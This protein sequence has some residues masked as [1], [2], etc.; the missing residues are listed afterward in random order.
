MKRTLLFTACVLMTLLYGVVYVHAQSNPYGI[1]PGATPVD[2]KTIKVDFESGSIPEGWLNVSVEGDRKWEIRSFDENQYAQMTAFKSG[3]KCTTALVTP[4]IAFAPNNGVGYHLS[5]WLHTGHANGAKMVAKLLDK[6]G[7]EVKVLDEFIQADHAGFA[8]FWDERKVFIPDTTE[9][10]YISFEYVGNDDPAAGPILTTT[11]QIDDIEIDFADAKKELTASVESY[12]F[13]TRDLGSSQTLEISYLGRNLPGEIAF[14]VEESD[15]FT[16]APSTLPKE[17]GK[18]TVTFKPMKGGNHF[19]L[20]KATSGET[21]TVTKL[22][23]RGADKNN[24]YNVST[25]MTPK[26]LNEDFETETADFSLPKYWTEATV[27]ARLSWTVKKYNGNRLI[28]INPFGLGLEVQT[29]VVTPLIDMDPTKDY[30]L[31]FDYNWAF[32][33]GAELAIKLLDAT[34]KPIQEL[35][36][37]SHNDNEVWKK[38]LSTMELLLPRGTDDCFIAFEYNGND[39]HEK[40]NKRTTAYQLDNIRVYSESSLPAS[41]IEVSPKVIDFETPFMIDEDDDLP[42][43]VVGKGLTEEISLSLKENKGFTIDKNTLPASGGT[44]QVH[45]EATKKGVFSTELILKS[46]AVTQV[47]PLKAEVKGEEGGDTPVEK[48]YTFDTAA[49][50]IDLNE[51]F[52]SKQMPSGW[53]SQALEGTRSWVIKTHDDNSYI[54]MTGYKAEGKL[55]VGLISPLVAMDATK[56]YELHFDYKVGFANGA[57]LSVKLYD[58]TGKL[59]KELKKIVATEPASGYSETFLKETLSLPKGSAN[60]FILFEYQGDG[61]SK[62]TTTYQIDNVKVSVKEKDPNGSK[63]VE[64][65]SLPFIVRGNEVVVTKEGNVSLYTLEG[66]RLFSKSCYEGDRFTLP[67]GSVYILQVNGKSYKLLNL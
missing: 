58:A 16:V 1:V 56:E 34:G 52:E 29:A 60:S 33:N 41:R 65:Q 54:Q 35:T 49:T 25:S 28:E 66:L 48:N 38:N 14:T 22:Y 42:L 55:V 67:M 64:K 51:D 32:A 23:G 4:L 39:T 59:V 2:C 17:G 13:Y 62:A 7:K 57:S 20:L 36:R 5:F 63:I 24:P 3:K 50:P 30:T 18:V 8:P 9:P 37:L 45:F 11:Y 21:V 43:T 40:A 6:E 31:S 47:V 46:G 61:A 27:K 44:V 19:A 12:D 15:A 10:G 26:A 53:S